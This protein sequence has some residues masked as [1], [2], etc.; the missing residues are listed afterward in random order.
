MS[1]STTSSGGGSTVTSTFFLPRTAGSLTNQKHA[2]AC[3]PFFQVRVL[4]VHDAAVRPSHLRGSSSDLHDVDECGGAGLVA[5]VR[6]HDLECP[7]VVGESYSA[8][9]SYLGGQAEVGLPTDV[10]D[11]D[12]AFGR[13]L[14]ELLAQRFDGVCF[15]A[16]CV[17]SFS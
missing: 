7:F 13:R 12:P 8:A 1:T 2:S 10:V 3:A 11:G 17:S 15:S 5:E 6:A 16:H 14:D 4:H 9:V